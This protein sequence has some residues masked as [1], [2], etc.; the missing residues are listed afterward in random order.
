MHSHLNSDPS[1]HALGTSFIPPAVANA[2][3][4]PRFNLFP[5]LRLSPRYSL[6]ADFHLRYLGLVLWRAAQPILGL[7]PLLPPRTSMR[8]SQVGTRLRLLVLVLDTLSLPTQL[9]S[10]YLRLR[11]YYYPSHTY[12][13]PGVQH[14]QPNL[15]LRSCSYILG[16]RPQPP[17]QSAAPQSQPAPP[18]SQPVAPLKTPVASPKVSPMNSAART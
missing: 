7:R 9:D 17:S 13:I 2:S 6:I 12:S 1:P 5:V 16:T 11:H 4:T 8:L 15:L 10:F 18:Q 14:M 3:R